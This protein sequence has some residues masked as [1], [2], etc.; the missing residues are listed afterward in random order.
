[1]Q[2]LKNRIKEKFHILDL[3]TGSGCLILTL[4]K[5]FSNATGVGT[6]INS[7]ALTIARKN[8]RNLN[9]QA[10]VKFIQSDWNKNIAEKFNIIISNPPYIPTRQIQSLPKE[11]KNFD[12]LNA[13]D[14]GKDG[15]DC[16]K[17]IAKNIDKNLA[18]NGYIFLEIGQNQEN[19][20]IKIFQ[21]NSFKLKST[22]KDLGGIIRV[23]CFQKQ[24]SN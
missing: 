10:K 4:L 5:L 17:Y 3:G 23:L 12:P 9:V 22:K 2:V 6:D 1:M 16:Y 7:K 19:D 13:L 11:V 18:K 8:A 21:K 15:L 20:I 14:G 24:L